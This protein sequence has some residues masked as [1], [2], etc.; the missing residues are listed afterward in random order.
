M[1]SPAN[2]PTK[3]E[4]LERALR[5]H[6]L[7]DVAGI[8]AEMSPGDVA[9]LI[10][11]SPPDYRAV[12]L[13]L[14][15][16]EQEVLVVNE[17]P[18]ELRNAALA[19][20]EPEALAEI[21]EQLDDDDVA[22]ILH[23]LPDEV[24]GQVLAIM[25]EQYRQRLQKVLSF[26]DDVAG[27]LMSTDTITI[28]A[29]L[30][31]DVVLRYL[32]RHTE[33]PPNMDSLIVVNRN[34]RFVGLLAIGT[35]LVSDPA[36]S[37]REM[38]VTDQEAIGA[39]TPAIE[40]ARR[41]ERN[42]W[43][44]APVVDDDG[45]LLGRITID[46]VV[47]VIMEE[48]D[49]SLTSLA[50]LAEE[51]TFATVWQSAPRRAVWL[52]VNLG[53]ALLASSVI[54]LFQDTIEKVVALAVLMPIVASMGGIAGTQSLTILI[55]AMA[56][57]QINHRN[58]LWLIGRESLVGLLNGLLWAAVIAITASLWFGDPMLGVIIAC[59]MLI[60]LVTAGVTGAGLPIVLRKL[61]VD[62]ALAGGVLVTTVTDIMGFLAFLGLATAFYA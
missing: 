38:M 9:Y 37:V 61:N 24:T 36:V 55:R 46:D 8:L 32:R 5:S 33:L 47:D 13:G 21:V 1:N 29:D 42:D 60:N 43:I 20:R 50:G 34:D 62:P 2:F 53:T 39:D 59:A 27:G 28:R 45:K 22:D 23:E 19:D 11:S 10:S 16:P 41:F 14:L 3:T 40:V 7:G 26:S 35:V 30:T 49:H 25:D 54:N 17:L 6:T 44:S 58:E 15:E 51:D 56:M 52:G 18:D 31:L 48:A 57:G 12:L 4:R